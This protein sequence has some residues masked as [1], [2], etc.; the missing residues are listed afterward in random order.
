[1]KMKRTIIAL[2]I[3][4]ALTLSAGLAG[5]SSAMMLNPA[6][7]PY[8]IFE[9][10]DLMYMGSNT[11]TMDGFPCA[12]EATH[13]NRILAWFGT[14]LMPDAIVPSRITYCISVYPND[15]SEV[16]NTSTYLS[17]SQK[18]YIYVQVSEGY[19]ELFD[20]GKGSIKPAQLE[21][22]SERVPGLTTG[23]A[24]PM[25][26]I[27]MIKLQDSAIADSAGYDYETVASLLIAAGFKLDK[28]GYWINQCY[29]GP[30]IQSVE[31]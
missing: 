13:D 4:L 28:K 29:G 11:G 21:G 27:S 18:N 25:V 1:M 30:M 7:F 19:C 3:I 14:G 17:S 9:T 2:F 10:P 6:Q 15:P 5:T 20:Y 16:V 23:T 22:W 26:G 8:S 12:L 31:P 24:N